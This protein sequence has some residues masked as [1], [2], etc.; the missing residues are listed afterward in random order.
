MTKWRDV[1]KSL[2]RESRIVWVAEGKNFFL[3]NWLMVDAERFPDT[4]GFWF[5]DRR[6]DGT[7]FAYEEITHWRPLEW[8]RPPN[9]V[10]KKKTNSLHKD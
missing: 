2:P 5:G 1:T 3:A 8:I 6:D 4:G 10:N 7:A 9:S